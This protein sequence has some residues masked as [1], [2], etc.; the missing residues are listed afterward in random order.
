L[1]YRYT[2]E[3]TRPILELPE[4]PTDAMNST[5][6]TPANTLVAPL[7]MLGGR[8]FGVLRLARLPAQPWTAQEIQFVQQAAQGIAQALEVGRLLEET[9]DRAAR[10][11]LVGEIGGQLRTTLDPDAIMKTTVQ[12]LGRLLKAELTT[13]EVMAAMRN[14]WI[15]CPGCG[16][17]DAGNLNP[18]LVIA[19]VLLA[20][21]LLLT[22]GIA[23]A[24]TR[25]LRRTLRAL[26]YRV[27]QMAEGPGRGSRP[28]RRTNSVSCARAI[29]AVCAVAERRERMSQE[30]VAQTTRAAQQAARVAATAR[31]SHHLLAVVGTDDW[32]AVSVRQISEQCKF[33]HVGVFL[34]DDARQAVILRAASSAVGQRL[35]AGGYKVL[36]AESPDFDAVVAH[37][38]AT[39]HRRHPE[40][41][42]IPPFPQTCSA[43]LLL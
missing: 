41:P 26:T 2:P 3:E 25:D 9:R 5:H 34:L 33:Y 40:R 22:L 11:H 18:F 35:L 38:R 37:R 8:S 17:C 13:I 19:G 39:F 12:A 16:G 28:R 10:D 21:A 7:R 42:P 15:T 32:L 36:L 27:A 29:G 43:C 1:G 20:V 23:R 24:L 4:T 31:V 30:T 6:V 14:G